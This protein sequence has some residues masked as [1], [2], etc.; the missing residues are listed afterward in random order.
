MFADTISERVVPRS[1]TMSE[2]VIFG[3]KDTD[4]R[5]F[6]NP[7]NKMHNYDAQKR[8]KTLHCFEVSTRAAET[9]LYTFSL[10]Q[11]DIVNY[12]LT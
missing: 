1:T 12:T 6:C 8:T 9:L 5:A 4:N 11:V 3:K 2:I 10:D 7:K